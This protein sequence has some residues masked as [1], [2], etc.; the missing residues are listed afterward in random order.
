MFWNLPLSSIGL[1]YCFVAQQITISAYFPGI[2]KVKN[3][4]SYTYNCNRQI[5]DENL[6]Q[7]CSSENRIKVSGAVDDME[8][9]INTRTKSTASK[10]R[11]PMHTAKDPSVFASVRDEAIQ[12]GRI[13]C[14][15][16]REEDSIAKVFKNKGGKAYIYI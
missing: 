10:N 13:G 3:R 8:H 15:Q 9:A 11:P 7:P 1:R 16:Y 6:T 12:R 5:I 14:L 4:V 2:Y